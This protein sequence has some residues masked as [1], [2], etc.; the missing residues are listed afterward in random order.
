MF[1][2]NQ[3]I[4]WEQVINAQF[5]CWQIGFLNSTSIVVSVK[6]VKLIMCSRNL[7]HPKTGVSSM[8]FNK[9]SCLLGNSSTNNSCWS[10][11]IVI[12]D[13]CGSVCCIQFSPWKRN[14]RTGLCLANGMCVCFLFFLQFHFRLHAIL[15]DCESVCC[16]T[17]AIFVS[18][19]KNS[20]FFP[21]NL[22]EN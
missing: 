10:H 6:C 16:L 17:Q 20:C 1:I 14:F 12:L 13:W 2:Y 15:S 5:T 7:L 18:S 19:R 11:A 8:Y 3:N 21:F 4:D 22:I 9:V